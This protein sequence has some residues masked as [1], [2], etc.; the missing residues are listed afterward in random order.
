MVRIPSVRWLLAVGAAAALA[1]A[2]SAGLPNPCALL[3]N[4][5]VAKVLGSKV[6]ARELRGEG[7]TCTWT[8]VNLSKPGFYETHRSL[9]VDVWSGTRTEFLKAA[10]QDPSA[11]RV[12]GFGDAA[13]RAG[14]G[15]VTF[16]EI[17]QRGRGLQIVA[18]LV[19][20]PL[21]AEKQ[22]AKLALN[23]L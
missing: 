16:L 5:E 21:S 19:T 10:R 11:V 12:K 13:Y 23:R 8:G 9:H 20:D 17:W 18:S 15:N 14:N 6:E 2:A 22:A 7:H 3:T 4:S 1:P